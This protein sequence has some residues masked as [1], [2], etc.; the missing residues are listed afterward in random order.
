MGIS[1]RFQAAVYD[2]IT[3]SAERKWLGETR[4]EVIGGLTGKILE[5]GAGTGANFQYYS[6]QAQVTAIEPSIHFFKRA[7]V[8]LASA[9]AQIELQEANAHALPFADDTFDA[10]VATLV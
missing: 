9:Q 4:R 5:I 7:Q 10:V 6:P 1:D 2:R 8:K 3:A